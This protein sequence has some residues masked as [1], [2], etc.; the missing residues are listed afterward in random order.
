M[1][2]YAYILYS[3]DTHSKLSRWIIFLF[4]FFALLFS[5]NWA[6]S[7]VCGGWQLFGC[8]RRRALH[9]LRIRF[10]SG[11]TRHVSWLRHAAEIHG[12]RG[13]RCVTRR[14]RSCF[15]KLF[16]L[17]ILG[18]QVVLEYRFSC[19]LV[20][21]VTNKVALITTLVLV[22]EEAICS[23]IVMKPRRSWCKQDSTVTWMKKECAA[24]F[25]RLTCSQ[26]C[27]ID[28]PLARPLL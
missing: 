12:L 16:K 5:A 6:C 8:G 7:M 19:F 10:L 24:F 18:P 22:L 2:I 1:Q 28:A 27:V 13:L 14:G 25:P 4:L 15:L 26:V 20:F 3:I 9:D 17:D 21:R 11:Y 23:N